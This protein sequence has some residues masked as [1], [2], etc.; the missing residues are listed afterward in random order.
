MEEEDDISLILSDESSDEEVI[1]KKVPNIEDNNQVQR[2]DPILDDQIDA[3]V[4]IGQVKP[5]HEE[6]GKEM[7]EDLLETVLCNDEGCNNKINL[8]KLRS[9]NP[10]LRKMKKGSK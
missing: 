8:I 7:E 9:L 3:V 10:S 6:E 5:I 1:F 2:P 4:D